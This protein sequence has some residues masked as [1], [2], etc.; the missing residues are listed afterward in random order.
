[1]VVIKK[2][3]TPKGKPNSKKRTTDKSLTSEQRYKDN[4]EETK[5]ISIQNII[6]NSEKSNATKVKNQLL[7][8]YEYLFENIATASMVTDATGIPQKCLTRYKRDL[9]KN[10]KLF[11]LEKKHCRKTGFRAWYL[12]T[13]PQLMPTNNQLNLFEN[14]K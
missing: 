3:Q 1:M 14:G 11:E 7:R 5:H 10:G 12:T 2:G 6:E 9:E 8:F 4:S 13:N